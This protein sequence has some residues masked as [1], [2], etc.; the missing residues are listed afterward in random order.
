MNR[1]GSVHSDT[2]NAAAIAGV[3]AA[4]ELIKKANA[5]EIE[6][7]MSE[8]RTVFDQIEKDHSLINGLSLACVT[9]FNTSY[10]YP[11]FLISPAIL[12][13]L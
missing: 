11:M 7:S 2:A 5:T 8:A 9:R 6:I 3:S 1:A 4:L 12:E 10:E 13:S